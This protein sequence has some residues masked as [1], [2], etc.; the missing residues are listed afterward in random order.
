MRKFLYSFIED[1]IQQML[2]QKTAPLDPIRNTLKGVNAQLKALKNQLEKLEENC[3]RLEEAIE[4][5]KPFHAQMTV[6]EAWKKNPGV[7]GVFADYHLTDCPSC[8]VG[9][10]ERL[11][12]AAFGYSISIEELLFKLNNLLLT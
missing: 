5:K 11:E 3:K 6:H 10:D 2:A 7:K 12:E 4:E 8:P 9:S 1:E